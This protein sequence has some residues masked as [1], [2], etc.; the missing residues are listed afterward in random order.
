MRA[1]VDVRAVVRNGENIDWQARLFGAMQQVR[2]PFA[3]E[4]VISGRRLR[5]VRVTLP[6]RRG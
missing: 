3:L 6:L 1:I 5:S 4:F 2:A